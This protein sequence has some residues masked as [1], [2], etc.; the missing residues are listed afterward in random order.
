MN[1]MLMLVGTFLEDDGQE[2]SDVVKNQRN[3]CAPWGNSN[4]DKQVPSFKP[5]RNWLDIGMA[6]L[7]EN[8]KYNG[9]CFHGQIV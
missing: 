3:L 8:S 2:K 4:D 6:L 9:C 7:T 5:F 1:Q